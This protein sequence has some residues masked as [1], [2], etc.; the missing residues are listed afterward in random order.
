MGFVETLVSALVVTGITGLAVLWYRDPPFFQ[1]IGR[2]LFYVTAGLF[3]LAFMAQFGYVIGTMDQA[4]AD[5]AVVQGVIDKVGGP[6]A[7]A[8]QAD[9]TFR[10]AIATMNIDSPFL[11]LLLPGWAWVSMIIFGF[12]LAVLTSFQVTRT[13]AKQQPGQE[14]GHD[15]G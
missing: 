4:T 12:V 9:I 7:G 3:M 13:H 10:K 15:N 6:P 8:T 2:P 5:H 1:I 14:G 11:P